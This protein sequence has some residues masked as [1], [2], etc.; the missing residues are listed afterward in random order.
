MTRGPVAELRTGT[1]RLLAETRRSCQEDRF[2][3]EAAPRRSRGSMPRGGRRPASGSTL[4][5]DPDAA[6]A[7]AGPV[8]R[9]Q[10]YE[11]WGGAP[12]AGVVTV[13]G[14]VPAGG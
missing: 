11:E 6:D 5:L 9:L 8:G 13:I 2:A 3:W 7:R 10:M 1:S 4:L 12:A 14:S